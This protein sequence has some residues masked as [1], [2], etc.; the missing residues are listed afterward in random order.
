M[1][2]NTKGCETCRWIN[3]RLDEEPCASCSPE[4]NDMWEEKEPE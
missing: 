3:V 1:M 2:E 4:Y